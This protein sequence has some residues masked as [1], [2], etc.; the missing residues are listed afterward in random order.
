MSVGSWYSNFAQFVKFQHANRKEHIDFLFDKISIR[1][2]VLM[3]RQT[4]GGGADFGSIHQQCV[5]GPRKSVTKKKKKQSRVFKTDS[6][7]DFS[8]LCILINTSAV[9]S[10]CEKDDGKF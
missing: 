1:A 4:G 6:S 8:I 7:C 2:C 10:L 5:I 9:E 3:Y